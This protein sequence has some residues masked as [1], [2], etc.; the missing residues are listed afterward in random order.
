MLDTV[1]QHPLHSPKNTG[2]LT[3]GLVSPEAVA[4]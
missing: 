1:A 4:V 2:A 3:F